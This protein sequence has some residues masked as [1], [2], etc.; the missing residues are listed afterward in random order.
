[1]PISQGDGNLRTMAG[2]CSTDR[3]GAI[4]PP[5]FCL[6]MSGILPK[7]NFIS[8]LKYMTQAVD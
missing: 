7:G 1:M 5:L 2:G 6:Q 4:L 3:R 8:G